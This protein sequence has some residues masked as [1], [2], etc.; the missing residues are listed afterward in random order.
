MEYTLEKLDIKYLDIPY[1]E[2]DD[3]KSKA[4]KWDKK[5]RKK[6]HMKIKE[7]FIDFPIKAIN[8]L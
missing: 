8:I 3:A 7:T 6:V 2:R 4:A 5:Q 1:A